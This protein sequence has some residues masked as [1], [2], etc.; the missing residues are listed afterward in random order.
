VAWAE[1]GRGSAGIGIGIGD[2]AGSP[3]FR[4]VHREPSVAPVW[5]ARG[6]VYST[7]GPVWKLWLL[8]ANGRSRRL[9]H[10]SRTPLMPVA[11]SADGSRLLADGLDGQVFAVDVPSGH[12]RALTPARF[13]LSAVALSRDG[14]TAYIRT[15]GCARTGRPGIVVAMPWAGGTQ[16]VVARGTCTVSV[17]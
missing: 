17:H 9:L 16:H 3:P 4:I 1:A 12:V 14:Q 7:V 11:I 6:I 5:G 10:R 15:S 8:D 13:G 2:I